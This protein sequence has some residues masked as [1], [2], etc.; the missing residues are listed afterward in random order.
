METKTVTEQ[1][2]VEQQVVKITMTKEQARILRR[3]MQLNITIPTIAGKYIPDYVATP[4]G[5]RVFMTE[6]FDSL[7]REVR[8]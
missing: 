1:V 5:V 2:M 6:L 8:H 3:L 4:D 7:R